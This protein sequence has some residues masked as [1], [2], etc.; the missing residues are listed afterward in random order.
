VVDRVL[1]QLGDVPR[2]VDDRHARR[3]YRA[4]SGSV[5]GRWTTAT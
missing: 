4:G 3:G 2:H 1:L 5:A